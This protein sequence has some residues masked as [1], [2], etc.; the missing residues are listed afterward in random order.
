M[1]QY[2][3]LRLHIHPERLIFDVKPKGPSADASASTLFSCSF[4]R[5]KHS[6]GAFGS[7]KADERI[8]SCR[9]SLRFFGL[10]LTVAR[11]ITG[12]SHMALKVDSGGLECLT[13]GD[14]CFGPPEK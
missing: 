6:L 14:Q 7:V 4:E 3:G 10:V 13:S 2:N 8:W 12:I 9:C 11:N 5:E 1:F